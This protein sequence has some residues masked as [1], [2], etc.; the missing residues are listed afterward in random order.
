[1]KKICLI[2]SSGGHFEQLIR[3]HNLEKDYEVYY[4][5]E[6][7]P[8]KIDNNNTYYVNQIN[9]KEKKFW[10]KFVLLFFESLK[11]FIKEKPDIIISTGALSVIPTFFIGKIFGKKL[12][13]I[14]SFAKIKSPTQTG[15]LLYKFVDVFIVQWK[16]MLEYYPNAVYLGSIY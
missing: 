8:Y 3:L 12:I 9:R 7:T 16:S 10:L 11:I 5:T 1:M 14:E 15:H 2:S 4:V 13:F 6:S